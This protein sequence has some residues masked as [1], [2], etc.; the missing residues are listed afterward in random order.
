MRI[1]FMGTPEFA[2]ASLEALTEAGNEVAAVVTSPDKPAGRGL[3]MQEPAVKRCAARLGLPVLQPEK[4]KDPAFLEA[5]RSLRA[6]L[7][8]VVAFRMLPE[9]VWKMPPL[10]TVNLHASLLPQYRGAAPINW[11]IIRGETRSGTTVFFINSEI[12]TGNII[13]YR[14]EPISAADN[15]GTLHDRLML[16]GAAHLVEAVQS[17]ATGSFTTVPQDAAAQNCPLNGAPK[18][19]RETCKIDWSCD[20]ASLHNL[21]RGL[22][23]HPAAWTTLAL[24][25]GGRLTMKIYETEA[26][27][28][29]APPPAGTIDSDNRTRLRIAAAGGWLVIRSLQTEGKKRMETPDFLRGMP[30]IEACRAE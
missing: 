5:L 11:A 29:D 8:A 17:I 21:V 27:P 9:E 3:K 7:F 13:S 10:G 25:R 12:D 4:L 14:E 22:S 15:A 16:G 23:P 19:F 20:A 30:G 24:P 28:D 6:D 26:Q 2:A 1:V 18:I